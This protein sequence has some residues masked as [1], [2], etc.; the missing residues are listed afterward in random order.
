MKRTSLVLFSVLFSLPLTALGACGGSGST[1]A[2]GGGGD[3]NGGG[4]GGGG[5]D[6]A[7]PQ[8][9]YTASFSST[10]TKYMSTMV[11]VTS[12]TEGA[13]FFLTPSMTGLPSNCMGTTDGA[14][15][16]VDC[17]LEGGA[18]IDGGGI[19]FLSAGTVSI[20][21][22]MMPVSLMRLMGGSYFAQGMS[23][24]WAGGESL[25]AKTTGDMAGI[26]APLGVQVVAPHQVTVTQPVI[27][28][29]GM[30]ITVNRAQPFDVKW[31]G[32]VEGTL[33]ASITVLGGGRSVAA[34]CDWPASAGTGSMT[35][36]VLGK[37]PT[38]MN[39]GSGNIFSVTV[40]NRTYMLIGEV[41]TGFTAQTNGITGTG[42]N[43]VATVM[44]Q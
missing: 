9:K 5:G 16:A 23:V 18:A 27:M 24:L 30:P 42:A 4:D 14:C 28:S 39:P 10:M 20:E 29:L 26:A 40:Q 43:A 17:S 15:V 36:T 32:G 25:T 11:S 1:T 21:G 12:H 6:T 41:G 19:A 35:T 38:G 33:H 3:G 13:S 31:T 8:G 34:A 22:G 7:M 2:D 37:L 44:I